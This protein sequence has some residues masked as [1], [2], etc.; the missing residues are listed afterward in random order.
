MDSLCNKEIIK[1]SEVNHVLKR[2]FSTPQL[3]FDSIS[4]IFCYSQERTFQPTLLVYGL[5][6]PLISFVMALFPSGYSGTETQKKL[7]SNTCLKGFQIDG[8]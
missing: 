4:L 6:R 1:V 2:T 3:P 8:L 7:E 5:G